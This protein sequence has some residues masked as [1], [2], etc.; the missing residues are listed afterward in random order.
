VQVAESVDEENVDVGREKEQVLDE[1]G[2]HV[3]RVKEH[4]GRNEVETV[5]CLMISYIS[6]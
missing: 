2:D 4:D 6:I 1:R 5:C 3:P